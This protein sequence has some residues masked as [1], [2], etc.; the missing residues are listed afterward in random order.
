MKSAPCYI[1]VAAL[2]GALVSGTLTTTGMF[3]DGLIYSNIA[4]NMAEGIGSFWHPVYTATHHP[5]FYQ[6]PPLAL[7]LLALF[8][9]VLG[10]HLWVTKFYMVLT[11]LLCAWLTVKLWMRLGGKRENGWMP[12]LMWTL[13]PIVT[14]FAFQG[15]LEN[16]MVL[17]DLGAILLLLR[18]ERKA[19]NGLLAG[20]LLAA[21]FLTKGFTGLF[22]L[23]LP[24]LIWLLD[25]GNVPFKAMLVQSICMVASLLLPLGVIAF[26]VPE[27]RVYFTNYMQHQVVAGWSQGEVHRWQILVYF[28]RSTAI[29]IGVVLLVA[30]VNKWVGQKPTRVQWAMWAL[31]ACAVLP[32]MVSTHQREFYLL[33]AMPI[34]AVLLALLI[35]EPVARWMKPTKLVAYVGMAMLLGAVVLNVVRFGSEGRDVQLQRDMKIIAPQLERGEMVTVP[36][37]LY[38]DYKLQGYYYRECRVSL[39]DQHRHRHLLTTDGYPVDSAYC[40]VPLPTEQYRLYAL[41][42]K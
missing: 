17:F 23:V 19:L 38:F 36:T 20:L 32:M 39:D 29:A 12:L 9:K 40:E 16:T 34:V 1:I 18:S 42:A 13:V 5:D 7:G 30:I 10:T 21:A 11:M 35:E 6:H 8:Y 3:M 14:H 31:V 15:M 24:L 41:S 26:A 33:T 27:A 37:P 25:T 22:P 28:L 2:F 4:A